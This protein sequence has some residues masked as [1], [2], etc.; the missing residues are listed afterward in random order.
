MSDVCF[1]PFIFCHHCRYCS[2]SPSGPLKGF[3]SKPLKCATYFFIKKKSRLSNTF[4]RAAVCHLN[5]ACRS[6]PSHL[7]SAL[8]TAARARHV[9]QGWLTAVCRFNATAYFLCLF[10][11]MSAF[12]GMSGDSARLCVPDPLSVIRTH[13]AKKLV[14]LTNASSRFGSKS[15]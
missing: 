11:L 12:S 15:T 9:A 4:P 6:V 14:P 3:S 13:N 2:L 5:G 1:S 8:L 10:V 7:R